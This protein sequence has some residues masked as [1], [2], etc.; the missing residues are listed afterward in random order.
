MLSAARG[1]FNKSLVPR[2][3]LLEHKDFGSPLPEQF[4]NEV[5]Q[6]P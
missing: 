6:R 4:G 3:S 2:N 5:H 1:S